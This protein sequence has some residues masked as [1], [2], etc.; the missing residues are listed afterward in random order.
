MNDNYARQVFVCRHHLSFIVGRGGALIRQRSKALTSSIGVHCD[1]MYNFSKHEGA[2][3]R[4]KVIKGRRGRE[5]L[6]KER[7][8]MEG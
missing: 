4:W 5:A 8:R 7:E 1:L 6:G 2:L 3:R